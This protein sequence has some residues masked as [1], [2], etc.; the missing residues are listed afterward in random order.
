M[1]ELVAPA[2]FTPMFG[3][4]FGFGES[5]FPGGARVFGEGVKSVEA[6]SEFDPAEDD[7]EEAN[8]EEAPAPVAPDEALD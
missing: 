7:P 1:P 8:D 4:E 5:A 3:V 2:E 6:L